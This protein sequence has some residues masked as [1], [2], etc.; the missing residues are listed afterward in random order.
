MH[1][2]FF[3]ALCAGIAGGSVFLLGQKGALLGMLIANFAAL[4]LIISGLATNP[5]NGL[6]SAS[7]ATLII[8]VAT[9]PISGFMFAIVIALP[10]WIVTQLGP[11]S[12]FTASLSPSSCRIGTLVAN[13]ALYGGFLLCIVA[14]ISQYNG[15]DLKV[16]TEVLLRGVFPTELP[17]PMQINV[18]NQIQRIVSI[19]PGATVAIWLIILSVN[20]ALAHVTTKKFLTIPRESPIYSEIL[21]PEWLYWAFVLSC[22]ISIFSSGSLKYLGQNLAI[23][24]G[25]CFFYIGLAIAHVVA[26]Q[27]TR[28]ILALTGLY[29]FIIALGWPVIIAAIV[30]FFERWIKIRR[31]FL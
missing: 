31:R 5:N 30:G 19:L 25:L 13:M 14:V 27:I 23:V 24:F 26:K 21:A 8:A 11:I 15:N 17:P 12:K 3:F 2:N 10:S 29:I 28:P 16:D 7:V 18:N 9:N 20:Y 22:T 6:I 1:R 4:P